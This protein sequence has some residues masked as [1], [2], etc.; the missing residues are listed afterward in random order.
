MAAKVNRVNKNPRRFEIVKDF[1]VVGENP[2]AIKKKYFL[3]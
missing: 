1:L 3:T 2:W